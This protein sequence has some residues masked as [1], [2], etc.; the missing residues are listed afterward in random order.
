MVKNVPEIRQTAKHTRPD[1]ASEH[2][3]ALFDDGWDGRCPTCG[4]PVVDIFE[5]VD[6]CPPFEEPA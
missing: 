1:P 5:H 3:K 4:R 6:E 2:R